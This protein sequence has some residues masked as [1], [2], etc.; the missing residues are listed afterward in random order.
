SFAS[1]PRRLPKGVTDRWRPTSTKF[2]GN[3]T[4]MRRSRDIPHASHR[5]PGVA[6]PDCRAD[7]T[8]S[9]PSATPTDRAFQGGG[10]DAQGRQSVSHTPQTVPHSGPSRHGL[11]TVLHT[12]GSRQIAI[13]PGALTAPGPGRS[14]TTSNSGL[15]DEGMQNA[16]AS[17]VANVVPP[18][19]RDDPVSRICAAGPPNAPGVRWPGQ[20][21]PPGSPITVVPVVS[22]A[23][24]TGSW[25]AYCAGEG[26]HSSVVSPEPT[27]PLHGNPWR[28]PAV[29]VPPTPVR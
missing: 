11:Q 20:K 27:P 12:S 28:A 13:V 21:L 5:F 9:C 18:V 10:Q 6:L 15:P 23:S 17:V 8:R 3:I 16:P 24:V 7:V 2:S 25:P 1:N 4:P 19:S 22:G 14:A 29:H 26:G